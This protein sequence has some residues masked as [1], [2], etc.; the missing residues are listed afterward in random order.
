MKSL[1]TT[2]LNWKTFLIHYPPVT[3]LNNSKC[4][5]H[6]H[7]TDL[8]WNPRKARAEPFCCVY[9]FLCEVTNRRDFP[10]SSHVF[11][12]DT[13]MNIQLLNIWNIHWPR[14]KASA[15]YG[16]SWNAS[17]LMQLFFFIFMR[18]NVNTVLDHLLIQSLQTE[19][20]DSLK[21][22]KVISVMSDSLQP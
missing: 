9:H 20:V 8:K 3:H 17:I 16:S 6:I 18:A 1:E 14:E 7:L 11:F 4:I 15:L 21:N 22:D 19:M 2:K 10:R 5:L 13:C 12:L